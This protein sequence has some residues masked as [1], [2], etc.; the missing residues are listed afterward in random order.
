MNS[1][2]AMT[3]SA[4]A[5]AFATAQIAS[6]SPAPDAKVWAHTWHLVLAKSKFASPASA[7]KSE[8]RAYRIT[9]NHVIMRSTTVRES[10]ELLHWGYSAATDGNWYLVSGNPNIDH[11]KLTGV[12]PREIKAESMKLKHPVGSAVITVSED[13]KHLTIDRTGGAAGTGHD[14]LVFSRVE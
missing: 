14:V 1:L 2:K 13:G 6:A 5:L 7:E 9:G 4:A 12:S 3:M 8:D 11:V 10:G